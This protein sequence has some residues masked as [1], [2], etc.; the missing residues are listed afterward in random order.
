MLDADKEGADATWNKLAACVAILSCVAHKFQNDL[1]SFCRKVLLHCAIHELPNP[2]Q[3]FDAQLDSPAYSPFP[4]HEAADGLTRLITNNSDPEILDAIELLAN[5]RVPSVRMVVAM[6]LSAVYKSSPRRFWKIIEQLAITETNAVVQEYIYFTLT[7]VV[8]RG[9]EEESKTIRVMDPM[10][11]RTLLRTESFEPSDSFHCT[12]VT[13]LAINQDN[14]WATRLVQDVFLKN[15]VRFANFLTQVVY[16]TTRYVTPENLES[17]KGRE[18]TGRTVVWLE[19]VVGVASVGVQ[20]LCKTYNGN[21]TEESEK[22]LRDTYAII[23]EV[24]TRLYFNVAYKPDQKAQGKISDEL[25]GEFYIEVKPLMVRVIEFALSDNGIMFAPTAH[26]FM[27]LL[28]RFLKCNPKEVLHLAE[29]VARSSQQTGYNLDSLAVAEV[30]KFVEIVL[31]DH[32]SD[33]REGQ[34]LEDLLNL[35]DIFA[36]VGW[37]EAL[38]VVWRLDEVFR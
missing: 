21:W 18:T 26:H 3:I 22:E 24:I 1:Y 25:L 10:L 27:E 2:D 7:R 33:V 11:R 19:K 12:R 13:W 32:R 17:S 8:G 28:R 16:K 30:V 23:N 36:E 4:R 9:D 29:S 35:L 20:Q 31:A 37:T 6:G 5:D 14:K 34:A 15:P 38:R